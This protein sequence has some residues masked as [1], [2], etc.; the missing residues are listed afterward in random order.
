[1]DELD[2]TGDISAFLSCS[3]Q[4]PYNN[5]SKSS[6]SCLACCC[7]CCCSCV[8]AGSG[9]PAPVP[10]KFNPSKPD[11][12]SLIPPSPL[13]PHGVCCDDGAVVVSNS[14]IISAMPPPLPLP[15][16]DDDAGPP[17]AAGLAVLLAAVSSADAGAAPSKSMSSRFSMLVPCWAPAATAEAAIGFSAAFWRCSWMAARWISSAPKRPRPTND[18]GGRWYTDASVDSSPSSCSR[19]AGER[20]VTVVVMAGFSERIIFCRHAD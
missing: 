12:I 3:Q 19:S 8:A 13:L 11:I 17:M 18:S 5:P 1:M 16:D 4:T 15:S 9:S 14:P 7:C 6:L 10:L 2:G 20:L